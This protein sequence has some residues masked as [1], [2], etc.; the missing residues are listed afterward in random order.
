FYIRALTEPLYLTVL[1]S[2]IKIAFIVTLVCLILAYPMAYL[3]INAKSDRVRMLITAG[4]LIPYWV[5]ML[6]RIFAWQ[7]ILQNN[8]IVNQALMFLGIT[9]EPVKLLYTDL[10]V[11]ISL[12]HILLPFMFLSLQNSM[13]Q[14]DKNLLLASSI[15]GGTRMYGFLHVFLPLSKS[16]MLSGSIMVFVLSLG[17]YIAPALLG[18]PDNMML[19]NLIEISMNNFN[20]GLASALSVELLLIVYLIIAAAFRFTGNIFVKDM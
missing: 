18:G 10:A 9:K 2:T 19:S 17:F 15:M 4:V 8:G 12:V 13:A 20:W 1:F 7:I 5:S 14:I 16:G 11:T 6:V 3:S